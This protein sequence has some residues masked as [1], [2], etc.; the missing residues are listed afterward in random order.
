M[1]GEPVAIVG[2]ACRYPDATSPARL[3]QNVLAR[4]RA[5]RR[6]PECRLSRRYQGGRA[7]ADLTYVTHAGVL[8]DWAFDRRRFGIPGPLYRAADQTHWLALET[9]ADAL[10][11]AGFPG[12]DGLDRDTAGVVLGN[13]LTG[14]FTR[15]ATLRL[16]WPFL[17]DAASTALAGA[18]APA[19]LSG[20]VLRRLEHLVKQPFPEP[21][22]EMLTGTLANTI[23]GRI[24]NHFDLHGTGYTVDGACSSSLLAV[25]TAARAL[26]AGELDFALAGGVDMSIDPLELI[27]FSRLGALATDRMRVYDE[28]P[29]GFLPGEGCGVIALMRAGDAERRGLREYAQLVG[30]ASSSDGAGGLSRP[31]RAGQVLALRRAYRVAGLAPESAGLIE[32]H[33]TGT[34]VG[35]RVEL[36][37]LT[38]VRGAGAAPAALSTVKANIGHTKAAAGVAGLIKAALSVFHRVLPPVTGCERPQELLRADSAP[39]RLL[40]EA[41]PWPDEIPVAGVS[42]MGFGGINAHV[43]LRGSPGDSV[44]SLSAATRRWSA[45]R[46]ETE[47][48]LLGATSPAD[49]STRLAALAASA[50]LLST[51]EVGDLAATAWRDDPGPGKLRAALV[52][53]DPDELAA[54]AKAASAATEGWSGEPQFDRYGGF[55]LGSARAARLGLLFPGQAAPVRAALPGWAADLGVPGLPTGSALST[56][57]TSV[58]QPAIVRQSLAAL[59]W[60]AEL[61]VRAE[62]AAGH[63]LGELTALRWAGCCSAETA[64]ELAA[65]RGRIM[66]EHGAAGTTMASLGLSDSG[67]AA[68][69]A[70]TPV[71]LAGINGPGQVVVSGPRPDVAEV[72][73][74]AR[75]DGV[76]ASELRVSHGFHSPAMSASEEPFRQALRGFSL[77]APGRPVFSTITGTRVTAGGDELRDLLVRQLT[78][79]VL[80]SR[81]L[82]ELAECCDLLLEA[83]PGTM[84]AGL[85]GATGLPVLSM[86]TGGEPARHAFATAVLAACAGADLEP[87]FAGRANRPL[88]LDAVPDFVVNPCENRTGWVDAPEREATVP[89]PDEVPV[90]PVETG[91]DPLAVL[92]AHLATTLELP[93]GSITAGSSLLGDLHLNSL[94]VVQ[95]ISTVAAELGKR[96]PD[97]PLSLASATV[98]DAAAELTGLP[99][100]PLETDSVAGVA[101]WVRP[102]E[103][104]WEPFTAEPAGPVR[105]TVHATAGHWLYELPG[106]AGE[107]GLAVEVPEKAGPAEVAELLG[108]IAGAGPER[109]LVVH[110]GHPAAAGI[111]RSAAVELSCAV[112]VAELPDV[113]FRPDPAMLAGA[114]PERY[115]ELRYGR[116]GSVHRAT[117]FARQPGTGAPE[118]LTA[119][120]VCLVTG[121]VSGITAYAAIALAERTG[122]ALVFTGRSPSDAPHV[123]A[124]LERAGAGVTARYERCDVADAG[125]VRALKTRCPG[126]VRGLL[127]GAGLNEPRRMSEVTAASLA[128]T[129]RPKTGGLRALLGEFGEE[130]KLVLGFGSIIGRQGL[131][132]QSEYCVAN[133]WLRV[134]LERWAAVHPSCRAHLLEW[135]VWSEIGMGVRL[136]V[137]DRL[138]RL[139]IDP[140]TPDR[141]VRAMTGV[142]D[143]PGSPVT[144]LLTSRFPATPTLSAATPA[145]SPPRFAERTR[146]RVPGVEA[147]LEADL[148][149]GADPY[150]DGHRLDGVPV[151]P[152]VVGLEAMRQAAALAGHAEGATALAEPRFRVPVTVGAS[153]TRVIRVAALTTPD[154]TAVELRDD[155]DRFAAP[156]FSAVVREASEPPAQTGAAEPITGTSPWYGSLF[157]HSGRFRRV[158]GYR[159][160]SAFAIDAWLNDGEPGPWFSEFHSGQLW[161]GDPAAHDATLHALLACVPHRLALP[162]GAEEFTV[163]REPSGPLRVL[164]TEL[165]HTDGEYCFDVG[166]VRPDGLAVAGWRSLRLRAVGT[167]DW[168]DGMPVR[169]IGPWLSRRLIEC[170][171]EDRLELSTDAGVRSPIALTAPPPGTGW[172]A[173]PVTGTD[174]GLDPADSELAA[175]LVDKLGEDVGTAATRVRSYREALGESALAPLRIDEVTEDGVVVASSDALRVLTAKVRVRETGDPVV[176]A[177]A[178]GR[179]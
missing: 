10:A 105:W 176:I 76:T 42:S 119:A 82:A 89:V 144:V 146:V 44:R 16:R 68:L 3:W 152:A 63:S 150:L 57:D 111:A 38:E 177:L 165:S 41:E 23:A 108:L 113:G 132:G 173:T 28:R 52:A 30:W 136:D 54:A 164:G 94:Q 75:A 116:D 124:G 62:A 120:D 71:V 34:E 83:G 166:L 121:G 9:A 117:L 7:D 179:R 163:W 88:P 27:G 158:A 95:I 40:A 99:E 1:T 171:I 174:A 24:C 101:N 153:D 84:L 77:P 161:L 106:G 56:V 128:A 103:Q 148:A 92:T 43:V 35:D 96:P 8:R 162:I 125:Q 155:T 86:D 133:D 19:E 141:G 15:A 5:F 20:D 97:T 167:R 140:I 127:H 170:G 69:L 47:I 168:P 25:M 107:P 67:V 139:G 53:R 31:E 39:L 17:A 129:L 4:R 149:L 33:G 78:E 87:W 29:T 79:P 21:G 70:G 172:A 26:A 91:T 12:G 55:A 65:V 115:L 51:A 100:A 45:R 104:R 122:C 13:S 50:E 98:A 130:L 48:V 2:M 110:C 123:L 93:A 66:A 80:F 157:F 134:E 156:R 32:G 118:P 114:A 109:L 112:V 6:I 154:G 36:E 22:E 135:S 37:A 169:L 102:F 61:G 58:A 126:P 147:V 14:E 175:S 72:L 142:L 46:E 90:N 145:G 59:A 143:D 137:L 81:A 49:L 178:I 73:R 159:H 18:G 138:R 151:L 74:R 64:V 11:D 85:A 131:A 60:L 160:L